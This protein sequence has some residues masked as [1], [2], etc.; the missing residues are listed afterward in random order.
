MFYPFLDE[1]ELKV[2]QSSS[3][4]STLSKPWVLEIINNTNCL[5]EPY[6]DLVNDAFLNHR[7]DIGPSCD[8]FLQQENEDVEN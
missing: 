2:G 4:T 3:Y 1:C 7:V 6:S 8:L 5:V